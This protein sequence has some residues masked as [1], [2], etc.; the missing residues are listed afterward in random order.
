M[1]TPASFFPIAL[2]LGTITLTP[3]LVRAQDFREEG[4][5]EI[6]KCQT[7]DKPGSYKLVRNLTF[8]GTSGACLEVTT[9]IG[10]T[11]FVT[12]DLAG[13]TISGPAVRGTEGIAGM[14]N[15][16][17]LGLA[18][19]NGSIQGFGVGVIFANADGIIVEGLRV[20]QS[21][22]GGIEIGTGIVR[23]NTVVNIIETQSAGIAAGG[24]VTGNFS[25]FNA[26]A[27]FLIAPGSTVIGNTATNNL[28]GI[29]VSCPSNVTD[30]TFVNNSID[31]LRLGFPAEGC[32]ITNNVAP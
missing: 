9:A 28:E 8:T 16:T 5:T 14:G 20:A 7:I 30:N 1:K 13:F 10:T 12:I 2:A 31:N 26:A 18:V 23:G 11:D 15:R 4:P 27:G 24:L 3:G 19:R 32:N 6:E 21:L 25:G 17:P 29:V 22:Q